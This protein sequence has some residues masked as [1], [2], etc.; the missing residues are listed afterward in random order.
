M[1]RDLFSHCRLIH[2]LAYSKAR[3]YTCS[4]YLP[5]RS[6]QRQLTMGFAN[7]WALASFMNMN[8]R[9]SPRQ[10]AGV[11]PSERCQVRARVKGLL[12]AAGVCVGS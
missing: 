5:W 12:P 7:I 6:V 9:C 10:A 8:P 11:R 3:M 4:F 2:T 1:D